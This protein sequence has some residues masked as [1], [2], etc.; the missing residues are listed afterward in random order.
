MKTTLIVM[1]LMCFGGNGLSFTSVWA[2]D[3]KGFSGGEQEKSS[4][5]LSEPGFELGDSWL[6]PYLKQKSLDDL[7]KMVT[8][9]VHFEPY[10]GMLRGAIGAAI[11]HRGNSLDQSL[12]LKHVLTLQGYQ[13]RLVMGELDKANTLILLRGMYPPDIPAFDFSDMYDPFKLEKQEQL[14]KVVSKHYWLEV[15]Q[16]TKQWLPLDPS[17]PRAK[18]GETYAKAV[19]HYAEVP[20]DW[21]QIVSIKL[22]QKTKNNK[23]TT[24]F[25]LEMPVSELGYMPLSLSCMGV[26]LEEP[27]TDSK[28]KSGSATGLFGKSLNNSK[29]RKKDAPESEAKSR[30]AGTQYKWAL[31][32]RGQGSQEATHSVEF[33]KTKTLISKEWLDITVKIPGQKDRNIQRVLYAA[34]DNKPE[35]Q[36]SMYRRHIIEIFPGTVRPELADVIQAQFSKMPINDWKQSISRAHDSG[37]SAKVL[38]TDEALASSILQMILTRFAEASDEATDR[39]AYRNGIAV[40]RSL[41]RIL[42]ASVEL[43]NKALKF[44]MDL[45]LDEVDAV[46]FPGVPAKAASLFQMG[47]GMLQSTAEGNILQQLTGGSILTT[48]S[49]M[50]KAQSEGIGLKVVDASGLNRFIKHAKLPKNVSVTLKS[51]LIEGREIIIPEKPVLIAGKER[52]GW[53]HVDR[54]TGRYIGVMDNGLHAAMSEYTMSSHRISLHPKMGFMIGMIVGADS[55]L[56]SISGLMIKHGQVTPAMIKEVDD[57]LKKVMCSSC[58][59]AEAKVGGSISLGGDCLKIEA[60]KAIG[61][62]VKIDFCDEYINGFKCAAGLLMSGLTGQ[63]VNKAEIKHVM[64]YEAGCAEGKKKMSIS[65]GL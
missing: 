11:S 44:S 37:D 12:L 43:E 29:A 38:A 23:T 35:H 28:K 30:L 62:A 25:D 8:E 13:S 2:G 36:P 16:G 9:R 15:N 54:S 48:T 22:K 20:D 42:I 31:R 32:I 10:E 47:R 64:S 39:A 1:M 50:S 24:V 60:K 3:L 52:W 45:R 61:A 4:T 51:S 7:F 18:I 59:K 57:Y 49:L 58:P 34:V 56:F 65:R 17:F 53:W 46:P 6:K 41:P 26:P 40:I 27:A 55:T 63:S 33:Q 14:I 5:S 19:K 21:K